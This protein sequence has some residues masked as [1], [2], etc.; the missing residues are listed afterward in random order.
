M[1]V[2]GCHAGQHVMGTQVLE[3]AEVPVTDSGSDRKSPPPKP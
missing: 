3:D 2:S 1:L